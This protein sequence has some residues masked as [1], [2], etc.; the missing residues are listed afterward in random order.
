MLLR[1]GLLDASER[2]LRAARHRHGR[3][4]CLETA[5]G[6]L[7][8]A[9]GRLGEAVAALRRSLELR[10][11]V[12]AASDLASALL[13]RGE[14]S[15]MRRVLLEAL[16]APLVSGTDLDKL[17]DRFRLA[18]LAGETPRAVEHAERVLDATDDSE[19]LSSLC[20]PFFV[21]EFDFMRAAPAYKSLVAKSI[22]RYAAEKPGSPWGYYLRDVFREMVGRPDGSDADVR[23]VM[24][25][26]KPRHAWMRCHTGWFL[27]IWKRDFDTAARECAAAVAGTRPGDWT[28]QC[29]LAENLACAGRRSDALA[30]F[31]KGARLAP[32]H[33]RG[34]ALAWQGEILLWLGL[35]ER[36]LS[37]LDQA[38]GY[39][40]KFAEGW[41]GGALVLLGRHEDALVALKR[42]IDLVPHDAE[43][44]IWRAE[45]LLRLGRP[46][47]ALAEA[48]VALERYA[49]YAS[50]HVHAVAGLA[51]DALGDARSAARAARRLPPEIASAVRR[52]LGLADDAAPRE[53]M[54][55]TLAL[56][57]GVRRGGHENETWLR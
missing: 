35:A 17:K 34:E 42:A 44:R 48:S 39:G 15:K 28:A 31:R 20:R 45:A 36:A 29:L 22:D 25:L 24:R 41:R 54:E 50:F 19:A 51:H 5:W 52:K 8:L 1:R 53:L 32:S 18:I 49:G 12:Q 10:G 56:S 27:M 30:A 38:I 46:R 26:A 47:E 14:V 11:G 33:S 6:R 23:A 13:R 43:S 4:A 2:E 37:T 16:D 7:M 57:K 3:P 55:G 40:A 9:R 21:E